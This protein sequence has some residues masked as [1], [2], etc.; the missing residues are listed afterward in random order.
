MDLDKILANIHKK[1]RYLFFRF[2]VIS[3]MMF[4]TYMPLFNQEQLTHILV[5]NATIFLFAPLWV[6]YIWGMQAYNRVTNFSRFVGFLYT[7][8][9]LFSSVIGLMGGY[10]LIN[11][12]N[13]VLI[14]SSLNNI[15]IDLNL[16]KWTLVITPSLLFV[17]CLFTLSRREVRIYNTEDKLFKFLMDKNG[18]NQSLKEEVS[19]EMVKKLA[20]LVNEMEAKKS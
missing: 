14:Q 1:Q 19:E 8:I 2:V 11:A 20:D 4:F 10:S 6:E 9:V 13:E 15:V 3:L 17:D 12:E 18:K 5:L 7:S 16:F